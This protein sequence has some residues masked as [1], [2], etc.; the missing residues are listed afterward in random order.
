MALRAQ[1]HS[2]VTASGGQE[3]IDAFSAAHRGGEPFDAVLTDLGM[4]YV[5][6]RIVAASVKE[7]SP[8]TPI[9]LLTGWWQSGSDEVTAHVDRVIGKPVRLRDLRAALQELTGAS[10][11]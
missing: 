10:T 2:V 5:D 1:G 11:I 9:I 4:P 8:S 7:V 3:G 6:G